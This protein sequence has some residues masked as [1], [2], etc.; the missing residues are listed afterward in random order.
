[1]L[2][3]MLLAAFTGAF[4]DAP[5]LRTLLPNGAAILV[6]SMPDAKSLAVT[7]V[8]SSRGVEETPD[9]HGFRHLV[10]HLLLKGKN[11]DLDRRLESEGMFITGSTMRDAMEI[12]VTCAPSQLN[13]ALDA[14]REVLSPLTVSQE[15]IDSE[16][17]IMEQEFA[18][19]PDSLKLGRA[20]WTAAYGAQGLEPFGNFDAMKKAT[21]KALAE[22]D[23][24]QFSSDNLTVVVAGPIGMDAATKEV[25]KLLLDRTSNPKGAPDQRGAARLGRVEI[26]DALGEARA[27]PVGSFRD[28][29]TVC[30]LAAALAV[31]SQF[32]AGF[33]SYTPSSKGGL[34][35]VGRTD[36]NSG[37][38]LYIDSLDDASKAALY[39]LG[40]QLAFSWVDRQ[41]HSPGL[42][43]S[44]RG[45]LISM[46]PALKPEMMLDNVRSMTWPEFVGGLDS[47]SKDKTVIIVGEKL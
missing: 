46:G 21:P 18:L 7:L 1:M 32:E 3:P 11:K 43:A 34:I 30:V 29:K 19:Q 38:G 13:K 4:Q 9:R 22:I 44:L 25:K 5:R 12:D 42:N 33:V 10:E 37:V 45:M 8:A 26:T 28:K 15:D 41:L 35:T 40:K 39:S 17:R 23:A 20:A 2:V 6:E 24:G 16:L 47:L 31:A 36:S 27:A 14:L